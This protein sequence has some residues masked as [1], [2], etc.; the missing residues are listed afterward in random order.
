LISEPFVPGAEQTL[1]LRGSDNQRVFLLSEVTRA[2]YPADLDKT[3]WPTKRRLD[4]MLEGDAVWMAGIPHP[5]EMA[6]LRQELA[7]RGFGYHTSD[8]PDPLLRA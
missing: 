6:R 1:A 5:G 2:R 4:V 7:R 8:Q 3:A